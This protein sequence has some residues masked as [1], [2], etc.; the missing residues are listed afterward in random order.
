MTIFNTFDKKVIEVHELNMGD[1]KILCKG[2]DTILYFLISI[3]CITYVLPLDFY[4][5]RFDHLS[6][7]YTPIT[8]FR[9]ATIVFTAIL[10]LCIHVHTY[11]N[12]WSYW[13]IMIER[14]KAFLL[15][16]PTMQ[17][18]RSSSIGVLVRDVFIS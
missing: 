3:L 11:L 12:R 13:V 10:L 15:S 18:R 7:A 9:G 6:T 8:L 2:A 16:A 5:N 4:R 17:R 1:N 14:M